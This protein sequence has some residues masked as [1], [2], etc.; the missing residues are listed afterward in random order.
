MWGLSKHRESGLS[1]HLLEARSHGSVNLPLGDPEGQQGTP[2]CWLKLW[3]L[4]LPRIHCVK[5]ESLPLNPKHL[6]PESL[7]S[8]T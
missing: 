2:T 5:P 1:P 4:S 6:L 7:C 3:V 8:L